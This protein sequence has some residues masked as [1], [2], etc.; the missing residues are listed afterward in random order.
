MVSLWETIKG[1]DLAWSYDDLICSLLYYYL[2][3]ELV[4]RYMNCFDW[5]LIV[6]FI[7]SPL[8]GTRV[9]L[10]VKENNI[11]ALS[12]KK[13]C[14]WGVRFYLVSPIDPPFNKSVSS[15]FNIKI[16]Y[17]VLNL[18]NREKPLIRNLIKKIIVD[19]NLKVIQDLL[20][21]ELNDKR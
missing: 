9:F 5:K 14:L 10:F 6:D 19:Q 8:I 4:N 13:E 15:L 2:N 11:R 7:Q 3:Y 17:R 16:Y 1:F 21:K 20:K 18:L 12:S